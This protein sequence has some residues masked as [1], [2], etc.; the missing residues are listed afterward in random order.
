VKPQPT[1]L[2]WTRVE[3]LFPDLLDTADVRRSAFL[4]QHCADDPAVRAELE[5]LLSAAQGES[6]LDHSPLLSTGPAPAPLEA[7]L[8][9]GERIGAWRIV[10]LLG[11]GGMGEVYLAERAEGGFAQTAAIKRLRGDAVEHAGRFAAERSILAQLEHPH[12]ARLL[13]GGISPDGWAWMAM[14]YVVGDSIGEYCRRR[15]PGL[16]SRMALFDQVCAAVAYA[17]AR[18]VVHRDLKPANILVTDEGQVKLLD[19]GIAK[20]LERGDAGHTHT[21]PFTP[22]HAAPEQLEGEVATTAVDIYALGVLLYEL[23]VG[24]RPWSFGSTPVSLVVDRLLREEPPPPSRVADASSP[25]RPGLL[26][27]DLDA[28]VQRCLRKH[29]RDRYPTVEALRDD[30]HCWREHLPVSARRGVAGYLARRWLWRHRFGVAAAVMVLAAL[31]GGLGVALWQ[32][33]RAELQAWRAEQVKELVLATFR[34]NDPLSRPGSERRAPAQMIAGSVALADRQLARDPELHAEFLG[35]MGEIQANLGDLSG[36]RDTLQRALVL[37]RGFR[38]GDS[39]RT[40]EILRKLADVYLQGGDQQQALDASREALAMLDRLGEDRSVEAARAKLVQ[41]MVLVNRSQREQALQLTVEAQQTF[42][43][44]LGHDHEETATAVFRHAQVLEQLRRDDEAIAAAFDAVER[45]QESRG[46]ESPRLI[47]PLGELAGILKRHHPE[48]ADDIYDRAVKLARHHFGPRHQELGVLLDRQANLHRQ[49][50]RLQEA[51]ALVAQAEAAM[52]AADRTERAQLLAS[53]GQ[54]YLDMGR[55]AD[56]ERDLRQAFEL[57]RDVMGPNAGIVWYTASLWGRALLASGRAAQAEQVQRDA[58]ARLQGILGPEAYQN[59][60]LLDALVETLTA[61]GRHAEAVEL[62]RRSLVLTGKTYASTHPLSAE[63]LLRLADA[64]AHAD[65]VDARAE[66]VARCDQAVGSYRAVDP[67]QARYAGALVTCAMLRIRL[68]DMAG[69]RANLHEALRHLRSRP[70][71]DP[72]LIQARH[73]LAQAGD[74]D[75][76]G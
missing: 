60:L 35:S 42:E 51:E 72:Q 14:E 5:S 69:A 23:L 9:A 27:G 47:A 59:V 75:G 3:A 58:L 45:L 37:Q 13:D 49:M 30:I 19:F 53:R 55:H 74:D 52:P 68:D 43:A 65:G 10:R 26:R 63:R 54:L 16:G 31:L 12:I 44:R 8:A 24:Q 57:R 20:L 32:A 18:L 1:N 17:H 48:E 11:R 22:D 4:D 28:I 38:A 39:P 6:T 61:R 70:A 25:A 40:A 56:A 34:E 50:G 36:G 2:Q 46:P 29:P 33:R 73:L 71:D 21:A 67:E 7:P 41:A 64:L 76:A 15:A 66:A 62:A